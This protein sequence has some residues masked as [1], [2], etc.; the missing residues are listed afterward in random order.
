MTSLVMPSP[1]SLSTSSDTIFDVGAVPPQL[2]PSIPPARPATNVPWPRPSPGEFCV[3]EVRF[4]CLTTRPPNSVFDASMPESTIAI[5]GAC[6]AGVAFLPGFCQK[7]VTPVMYGQYA[8][9]YGHAVVSVVVVVV[10]VVLL[11]PP[12]LP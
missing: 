2:L 10:V 11:P 5:A 4:T 3:S 1:W 12:P 7:P 9:S 8:P 6:G